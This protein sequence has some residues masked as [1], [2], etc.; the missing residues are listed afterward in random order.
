MNISGKYAISTF[1]G[2]AKHYMDKKYG[3]KVPLPNITEK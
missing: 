3:K 2:L 1:L